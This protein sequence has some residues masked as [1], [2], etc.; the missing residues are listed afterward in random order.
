MNEE[1]DLDR[2]NICNENQDNFVDNLINNARYGWK[3]K[4]SRMKNVDRLN[5][6]SES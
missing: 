5:E 1:I 2:P 6:L 4:K 3:P